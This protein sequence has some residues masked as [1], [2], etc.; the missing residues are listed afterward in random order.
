[1]ADPAWFRYLDGQD[2]DPLLVPV[3][4]DGTVPLLDKGLNG[5]RPAARDALDTLSAKAEAEGIPIRLTEG[6]RPRRRQAYLYA[7]GRDLAGGIVTK[8]KPG[9]SMHQ[10]GLAFDICLRGRSPYDG[11]NLCRLGV[12][13]RDMGLR[14]GGVWDHPWDGTFETWNAMTHFKDAPHFEVVA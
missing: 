4:Y 5:L 11:R 1:M 9:K 8:V 7:Q 10:M 12:M 14:W 13:G 2:D 6:W 3:G